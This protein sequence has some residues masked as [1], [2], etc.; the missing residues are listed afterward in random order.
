MTGRWHAG[1]VTSGRHAGT[2]TG[3]QHAGTVTSA[4][5]A[6]PAIG[7]RHAFVAIAVLASCGPRTTRRDTDDVPWAS[8]GIDWSKPPAIAADAHLAGTIEPPRVSTG[9]LK[10][11]ARIVVIENHRLPIVAVTAIHQRAG[12]REDGAAHGI[13]A[14]T[15][16]V[17]V[18]GTEIEA[19]VASD[20]ASHHLVTTTTQLSDSIEQLADALRSP[21]FTDG[22]VARVRDRRVR[23][24]E[25]R[26]TRRLTN[27]P[28]S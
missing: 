17:L 7:R 9:A 28:Q 4:R 5:H 16:D 22:D 8:S 18:R 1:T 10:S 13:A 14:L 19:S 2:V 12:G 20:H 15:A 27:P 6:G 24:L 25:E 3:R 26:R 11:G 23:E 21:T